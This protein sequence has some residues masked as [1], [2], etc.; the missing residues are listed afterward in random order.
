MT[1]RR[2][3]PDA[4]PISVTSIVALVD[5]EMRGG[6]G[7]LMAQMVRPA[8]R[9]EPGAICFVQTAKIAAS[10][11]DEKGVICLASQNILS[12]I[13]KNITVIVVPDPKLA[14]N[15]VLLAMY[16]VAA[17][18]GSID[19]NAHIADD[20]ILGVGVRVDAGAHIANGAEISDGVWIKSGAS[21]GASCV[22][23][24]DTI[25]EPNAV[26]MYSIIGLNCIIG[27]GCVIGRAGFGVVSDNRGQNS[28]IPHLGR[29]IIGNRC[30][31]GAQ[32][33]IDRGFIDDTEIGNN[34]MIDM[35]NSIGHNVK[36]GNSNIFCGRVGLAGSVTIGDNN[37]FGVEVGVSNH[38]T[39]GSDNIFAG[40]TG[41]T[42]DIGSKNTMAGFPAV[43]V[44]VFFREVASLR[45]L[46]KHKKAKL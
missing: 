16:P 23:G 22:I 21:I 20:V 28:I 11:A 24:K 42:K 38:V 3:Y 10:I 9:A 25:I 12:S 46:A 30:S 14:F 31:I 17:V 5:G 40:R 6:S 34:V 44:K 37:T 26:I 4:T 15:A 13:G 2:F 36:I 29:V 43:P 35:Y 8:D 27:A 33:V 19:K 45:R 7:D 18:E 41:V 32:T 39:I 1:D